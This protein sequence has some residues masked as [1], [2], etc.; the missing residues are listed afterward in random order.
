L[1]IKKKKKIV[2]NWQTTFVN[3][4]NGVYDSTIVFYFSVICLKER[5]CK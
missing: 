5:R 2:P 4:R 3:A 1:V